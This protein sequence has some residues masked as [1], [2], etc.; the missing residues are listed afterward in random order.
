MATLAGSTVLNGPPAR[1]FGGDGGP[2]RKASFAFAN[3]QNDCDPSLYDQISHVAID[4]DGNLY[5]SDSAN[6]RVRRVSLPGTV[7]TIAGNGEKPPVDPRTCVPTG[8]AILGD[9]G[10]AVNAR[11]HFPAGLAAHPA[12]GLVVADQQSNRIVRISP[13]GILT[14]IAGNGLHAFYA[15][16]VPALNSGLDWPTAIAVNAA[17]VIYFSELHSGRVA[18]IGADGRL[19]TVAGTGI[20]GYNGD[21]G[22]AT[23]IRLS[24]PTG[25]A[26]DVEGN[27]YI[28]DQGNHRVRK[29]TPA[30]A[31][32]TIAGSAAGFSGD[33]GLAASAQLD[34]PAD[35]KVDARG[36][37]Y[38]SDM[39]NHRVRR[40]DPSGI[41]RT[42]AGDGVPVRG[43][44]GGVATASSLFLPTGLAI[45]AKGDVLVVDWGNCLLRRITYSGTPVISTNGIRNAASFALG[46][47]A[48]G[49]LFTIFGAN[50]ASS[51]L[52]AEQSPWP[53]VLDGVSVR[54]N[55]EP[56]PL[57]FVSPAQINAQLPY[58]AA[59]GEARVE[60]AGPRG[61]SGIEFAAV[62]ESAIGVFTLAPSRRAIALN[63]DTSL[64]SP[65]QAETRGRVLAVFLTGIGQVNPA[66]ATGDA[67]PLT[68]LH[69]ANSPAVATLG[70]VDA[71]V[72]FLGLT[73]GF[74]GLAQ[75][76]VLIPEE[77]PIGDEVPLVLR[78]VGQASNSTF[79]SIR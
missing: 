42:V 5:V 22:Q 17:G 65:S 57:F 47:T 79:V 49:G 30:G 1:G 31:L 48:P 52:S 37:I 67:A 69:Y 29:V 38:I 61:A 54:V 2:A 71:P 18:R 8:G 53:T 26:L 40:I 78:S 44:D 10:P 21:S 20:P 23:S 60:V 74:I 58:A 14:T 39:L 16:Q 36:N 45:D 50:L 3:R 27:L 12:G 4:P 6:Q 63:Q 75:A 73:P 15:P 55:G 59:P 66:V 51:S 35:V 33:G 62:A 13:S 28:A 64:N 72:Q 7:T 9:G 56:A 76:N 43:P 41:I 32:T 68:S 19:V 11:L 77:A 24:S 46:P 25:L 34:R 70:G